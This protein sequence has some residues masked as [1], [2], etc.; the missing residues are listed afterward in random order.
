MPVA[1]CQAAPPPAGGSTAIAVAP[2]RA[3]LSEAWASAIRYSDGRRICI[4]QTSC[5]VDEPSGCVAQLHLEVLTNGGAHVELDE[6]LRVI[7]GWGERVTLCCGSKPVGVRR[8]RPA[9][10]VMHRVVESGNID[11]ADMLQTDRLDI[12]QTSPPTV[13]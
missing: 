1:I 4:R 13:C 11:T 9:L 8:R 6:A 7:G 12:V 10:C 5:H 2:L 3:V